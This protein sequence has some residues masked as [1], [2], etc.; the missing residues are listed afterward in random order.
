MFSMIT[1][2]GLARIAVVSS[3]LLLAACGGGDS[4]PLVA[5]L[6]DPPTQPAPPPP[7]TDELKL[8]DTYTE[9]V[10]GTIKS[11]DHWPAWVGGGRD[12]ID[13]VAC[14]INEDYHIHALLTIYKDGVRLAVPE[15]VGR[16]GGGCTYELHTHDKTGLIHIE[17]NVP[18]QFTLGQFFSLWRQPLTPT[19]AA[20][21]PGEVRYYI[22]ENEKLAR[23]TGDPAAIELT[24]HREV[25]II[26]GTAPAE[27]PK[28]RW[29]AGI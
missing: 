13:G 1:S 14:L 10:A 28:Y 15:A 2:A 18:K 26:S 19:T 6:P 9:L 3:V 11:Q 24:A 29:P 16:G 23:Y 25:V 17:T 21:L 4:K 12:T 8:A 7:P 27:L 20:G 5:Q 22:I